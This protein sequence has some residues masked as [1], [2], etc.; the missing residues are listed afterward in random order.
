M[1]AQNQ[2]VTKITEVKFGVIDVASSGDNTVVAAVTGK[3]IRVIALFLVAA[4]A[5]VARWESGASGTALTGQMTFAAN[6]GK[7]L[8]YSEAGWFETAAGQLLNLEL[9]GAVSVDGGIVYQ[10]VD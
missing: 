5:V 9:G 4:G 6:G 3:K 8:P 2:H 1:A 10:Y 7:V